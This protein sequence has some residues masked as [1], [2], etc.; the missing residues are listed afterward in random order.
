MELGQMKLE[1]T[2]D[3][4][5]FVRSKV[6]YT[7]KHN[8]P[9]HVVFK[10]I[11]RGVATVEDIENL[12]AGNPVTFEV[13]R[14]LVTKAGGLRDVTTDYVVEPPDNSKRCMVMNKEGQ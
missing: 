4:A 7:V 13:R 10:G 14:L 3:A 8:E 6:Y 1:G 5:L 2:F 11:K 12:Y 9:A